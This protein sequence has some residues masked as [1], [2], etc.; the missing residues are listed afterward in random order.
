MKKVFV[1]GCFDILHAGHIKFFEE[2]KSLGDHLTVCIASDRVLKLYKHKSSSIDINHK[3][4]IISSLRTVDE[5]LIGDDIDSIGLNFKTHFLLRKPDI[6]AVTEDDTFEEEKKLL[7]IQY[8]CKYVKLKKDLEFNKIST[9]DIINF[10]RA[11]KQVPLRVD[12]VGGWLDVPK[13]SIPG[14]YIINCSISPLVSIN[15]WYY[16]IGSGL[17][18]S[19]AF[20][21]LSGND[22]VESEL[23]SGVGWQDPAVIKETGLCVWRSGVYPVL[24]VKYNPDLLNGR[25]ALLWTG[26]NHFTP[27]YVDNDRDYESMANNSI[28]AYGYLKNNEY[29]KFTECVN[30][31]YTFQLEEGMT[32]LPVIGKEMC[33]KYCGGGFGGYALYMF[34]DKFD[35]EKACIDNKNLMKIEPYIE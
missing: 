31:S 6:L 22:A 35:R 29:D 3:V 11:P 1:S 10:I 16:E 14:S 17:G 25:M 2:A 9:S 27:N 7:C 33:K 23:D 19:A 26:T 4:R 13:Y 32:E 28:K 34:M 18:G 8:G 15:E 30:N 12:F 21:I 5:V 20:S 24:E